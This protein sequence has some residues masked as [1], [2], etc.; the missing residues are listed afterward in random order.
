MVRD[1]R[2]ARGWSQ[3]DLAARIAQAEGRPTVTKDGTTRRVDQARVSR[4]E[5]GYPATMKNLKGFANAFGFV[6]VME[7]LVAATAVSESEQELLDR[8]RV[9][10]E[11]QR[12]LVLLLA[13]A[14]STGGRIAAHAPPPAQDRQSDD[15]I[16]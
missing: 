4:L 6:S 1:M 9:L 5:L 13:T 8:F 15:F 2:T 16:E 11:A 12:R 10:D 3:A 7:W 14:F